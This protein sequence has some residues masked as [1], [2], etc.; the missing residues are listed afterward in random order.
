MKFT[1]WLFVFLMFY[2][3]G[4]LGSDDY[5]YKCKRAHEMSKTETCKMIAA[6]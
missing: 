2:V 3:F 1:D 5:D 4:A 6:K